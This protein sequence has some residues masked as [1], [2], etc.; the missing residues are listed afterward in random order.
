M[1]RHALDAHV[2]LI[3]FA[4]IAAGCWPDAEPV[5]IVG[6]ETLEVALHRASSGGR[7]Q[8]DAI[9]V[10]GS[11]ACAID[12]EQDAYC[13]GLND[14][15]QLGDGTT[16]SRNVP[17][18]VRVDQELVAIDALDSHTCALTGAGGAYCWGMNTDGQLGDGTSED[19]H[20]P[21][22]V[23][24][25]HEFVAL[26]V[27]GSHT[28]ALDAE[29][30]AYCWGANSDGQLGDRSSEDSRVPSRVSG[31]R[32][33]VAI[34]AWLT[35]TCAVE[36][37]GSGFCWGRDLDQ[38]LVFRE[39]TAIPS[40][41]RFESIVPGRAR[42]CGL[43][44]DGVAYCWGLNLSIFPPRQEP[45]PVEGGHRFV[46]LSDNGD[47][48][49]LD[50]LGDIYCWEWADF[51]P[52]LVFAGGGFE[53]ISGGTG[54]DTEGPFATDN[55]CALDASGFAYCRGLNNSGQLGNGT[56]GF[57]TG[58]VAFTHVFLP[59]PPGAPGI[60]TD[61]AVT[62]VTASSLTAEWTQV[63]DGLGNPAWYRLKYAP[64][65]LSWR[66]AAVACER[67]I[68]GDEVGARMSC[69][70]DGLAPSSTYDFQLMSFRVEDGVWVDAAYS[71]VATSTTG[72][73]M[74]DDLRVMERDDGETRVVWTQ[75]DDGTGS[76]AWYRLKHDTEITRWRDAT[77]ACA[78]TLEGDRIR[79]AMTCRFSSDMYE[80]DE[81]FE[82]QLMSFRVVDGVWR[83]A[84]YS[85]LV[86]VPTEPFLAP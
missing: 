16:T 77:I 45:T 4:A 55:V 29:G 7:W 69:V 38:E 17:T 79:A 21:V 65:P 60:V 24:G 48:C 76:P 31:D 14:H 59:A 36:A 82:I 57:G 74:V 66:T 83:D 67:T 44:N 75:V 30:L 15:G 39:P 85:N 27:G 19:R 28:C 54:I 12:G 9:Q 72:S 34:E 70:V 53:R 58:S 81:T 13:W 6:P 10:G 43:D 47:S 61:L 86:V 3:I 41:V 50:A 80:D 8:V 40:S 68:R 42:T 26:A 84:V 20:E 73:T 64:S 52:Q 63:D 32:T 51:E 22:R 23:A 2:V 1:S 62:G 18:R 35:R 78:R 37:D 49:A 71:G 33:F 56:S 46:E 11:Y 5:S 25:D